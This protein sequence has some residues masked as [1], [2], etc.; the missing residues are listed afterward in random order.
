MDEKVTELLRVAVLFGG[1]SGEH[2]VSIAS[3]ALVLNALDTNRF[4]PMPVYLD[5]HGY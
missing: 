4:L 5:R 3:V 1:R 2:D